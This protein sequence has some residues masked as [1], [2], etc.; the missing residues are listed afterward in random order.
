DRQPAAAIEPFL[1]INAPRVARTPNCL[2]LS[3][4]ISPP[5]LPPLQKKRKRSSPPRT[6]RHQIGK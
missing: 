4:P 6:H 2:S 3:M 5:P 1:L